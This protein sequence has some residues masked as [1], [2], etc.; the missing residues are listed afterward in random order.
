LLAMTHSYRTSVRSGVSTKPGQVN[1]QRCQRESNPLRSLRKLDGA[2][3]RLRR[4]TIGRAAEAAD[5]VRQ[6][7]VTEHLADRLRFA[8]MEPVV[9][10]R[11][12][13]LRPRPLTRGLALPAAREHRAL[14]RVEIRIGGL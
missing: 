6:L 7:R 10:R 11:A 12:M 14:Q 13:E 3:T 2:L 9:I 4:R 1:S 5:K 8:E